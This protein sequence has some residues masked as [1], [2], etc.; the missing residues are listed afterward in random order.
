VLE[1]TSGVSSPL[2]SPELYQETWM[3]ITHEVTFHGIEHSD[4]V[5]AAVRRWITRLE[6]MHD[7]ITKCSVV[8]SLPH[9]RHRHGKAFQVAILIE[10]PGAEI[11][12]THIAD[13]DV[14]V[15]IGEAFRAA[16]HQLQKQLDVRREVRLYAVP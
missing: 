12:T 7:R 13:E 6:H 16:R 1:A 8:V 2:G 10:V 9:K 15:A 4:A 14:Y 5:E 3:Q 11:A